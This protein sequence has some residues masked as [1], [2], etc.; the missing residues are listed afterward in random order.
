MIDAGLANGTSDNENAI[1][2]AVRGIQDTVSGPFTSDVTYSIRQTGSSMVRNDNN[3]TSLKLDELIS[4]LRSRS[5]SNAEIVINLKD[6]EMA[7]ALKEM[8]VVFA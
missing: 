6:R 1:A 5:G 8:G 2:K 3:A 7:R 4:L